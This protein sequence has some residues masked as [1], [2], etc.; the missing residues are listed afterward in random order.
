MANNATKYGT[1]AL[2]SAI[3]GAVIALV[4]TNSLITRGNLVFDTTDNSSPRIQTVTNG[5]LSDVAAVQGGY[6][7]QSGSE[8]VLF[9]S[10]T[11]SEVNGYASGSLAITNPLSDPLLCEAPVFDVT[12]ASNPATTVDVY[13]ATGSVGQ[14]G[15]NITGSI[16][17]QNNMQLGAMTSTLSGTGLFDA[18]GKAKHFKLFPTTTTT[19]PNRINITSDSQVGASLVGTYSVPCKI[20]G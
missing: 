2:G 14:M 20:K 4:V 1:V 12:T 11:L 9:G 5:A 3:T 13:A 18:G 6:L 19:Q 7:V 16:L 10:L 17:L 8:I 15:P